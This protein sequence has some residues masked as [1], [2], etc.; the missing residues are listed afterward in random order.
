MGSALKE[1]SPLGHSTICFW[2]KNIKVYASLS[3][4]KNGFGRIK[5]ANAQSNIQL[6][7][8]GPM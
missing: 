6:H 7:L 8:I 5:K 1:T 3:H 2:M 4:Y